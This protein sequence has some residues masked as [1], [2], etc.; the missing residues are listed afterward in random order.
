MTHTQ[1]KRTSR[2]VF[3]A[4]KRSR[5]AVEVISSILR[6]QLYMCPSCYANLDDGYHIHHTFPISQIT[7]PEDPRIYSEDN[8]VLLC[9]KC[10]LKQGS[11][12][13]ERFD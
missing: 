11:K 12:I 3:A 4:W 13:D 10:N 8:L 9:P 5:N 2:Q 7:N 6:R 1:K